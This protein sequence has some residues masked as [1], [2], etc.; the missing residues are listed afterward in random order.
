MSKN[1]KLCTSYLD[2]I[3]NKAAQYYAINSRSYINDFCV[4]AL[5]ANLIENNNVRECKTLNDLTSAA[6]FNFSWKNYTSGNDINFAKSNDNQFMCYHFALSNITTESDS[7]P[8]FP[9]SYEELFDQSITGHLSAS[10]ALQYKYIWEAYTENTTSLKND[11]K[12]TFYTTNNV[13]NTSGFNRTDYYKFFVPE[14][15]IVHDRS[16]IELHDD[17][18]ASVSNFAHDSFNCLLYCINPLFSDSINNKYPKGFNSNDS[19]QAIPVSI[20]TYSQDIT[21]AGNNI[22]FEP[23]LNGLVTVE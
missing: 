4:Y 7:E 9:Y 2:F 22:M 19:R 3:G 23:N 11:M 16:L 17:S 10:N 18:L 20:C 13:A 14:T 8:D 6:L 15:D 21:L 12:N 5:S 1:T